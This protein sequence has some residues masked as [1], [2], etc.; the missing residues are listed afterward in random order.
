MSDQDPPGPVPRQ[1]LDRINLLERTVEELADV[2]KLLTESHV[3][4]SHPGSH[5]HDWVGMP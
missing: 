5:T 3:N 2:V 1:V 4:H